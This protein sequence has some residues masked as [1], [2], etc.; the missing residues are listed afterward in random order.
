M[1]RNIFEKNKI[2]D[3]Q[4][5]CLF[6]GAN[7]SGYDKPIWGLIITPRCDIAQNKVTTVHYL[8]ITK[9]SDW[10]DTHL[11]SM[12]QD[13]EIKKKLKVLNPV[14]SAQKISKSLLDVKYKLSDADLEI[15]FA[16]KSLPKDFLPNLREYWMYHDVDYCRE[17]L[18][19]WKNYD[20]RL[21]ELANGRMERFLLLEHWAEDTEQFYVIYLT[22]VRHLQISTAHTLLQGLRANMVDEGKDDL[23]YDDRRI[24]NEYRIVAQLTSPYLEYVCQKFANAF[25]RIGIQDWPQPDLCTKLKKM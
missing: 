22:E 1:Q 13:E 2:T 8:P 17:K 23:F 25:F 19:H 5:G 14:F 6:W 12:L 20:N 18:P 11:V 24:T 4:Q 10:K 15:M 21:N 3:F 9:F 7:F 16:S